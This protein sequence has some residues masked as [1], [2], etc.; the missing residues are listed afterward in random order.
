MGSVSLK[1]AEAFQ[2]DIGRGI[3]RIDSK[4]KS[5]LGVSTGDIIKITGKKA[6]LAIVW[7]AHQDDEGLDM[8]RMDGILR[9]NVGIGLGEKARIEKVQVKTA[10]RIILAPQEPIRYSIGFDR[11]VKKRLSQPRS[12]DRSI[13]PISSRCCLYFLEA[14]A[15]GGSPLEKRIGFGC[16][17]GASPPAPIQEANS[18]LFGRPP[19]PRMLLALDWV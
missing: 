6:A 10:K 19:L 12:R 14:G 3:A 15:G 13:L 8:I 11:Y 1:V 7:Q 2:N 18:G 16:F 9:Q 17:L 5:K 4:A